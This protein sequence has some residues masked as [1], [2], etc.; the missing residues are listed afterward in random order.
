MGLHDCSPSAN[1]INTDG[2]FDCVCHDGFIGDGVTCNLRVASVSLG[3]NH[4]CTVLRGSAVCWG[5]NADGQ[6]GQ[7]GGDR[8]SPVSVTSLGADVI[9]V[10]A[11]FHH[12]CA[13]LTSGAVKCWGDNAE[14]ELGVDPLDV[15]S[16]S[17][18][19]AVAALA[20]VIQLGAGQFHTCAVLSGGAVKC[21][22]RNGEG[23]LGNN[24]NKPSFTPV[25]SGPL[26]GSAVAVAAGSRHT[27]ALLEG[28]KVSCW[29]QGDRRQ[30]RRNRQRVHS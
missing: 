7:T 11:G 13:L 2:A 24:A 25:S 3:A 18:P 1:C 15:A 16:S 28:G 12:A 8:S 10:A 5:S 19:I 6:L 14:G 9:Q 17:T 29:G 23:E 22:G 4:S 20:D 26:G 30:R 27:C 21:W